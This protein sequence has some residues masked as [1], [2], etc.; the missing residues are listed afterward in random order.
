MSSSSDAKPAKV[1]KPRAKKAVKAEDADLLAPVESFVAPAVV[2]SAAPAPAVA[3]PAVAAP[4]MAAPVVAAPMGVEAAFA[5]ARADDPFAT[6]KYRL[7]SINPGLCVGRRIDEKNPI[8]ETLP[9]APTANGKMWPEK[10]CTKKPTPGGVMCEGCAKKDAEA[11]AEPAKWFKG[12]YGRL[13]EPMY[14]KALV[15]GCKDYLEKYPSGIAG[16]TDGVVAS[17]AVASA[18]AVTAPA[19]KTKKAP[20]KKAA[21]AAPLADAEAPPA[22]TVVT[23]PVPTN[24]VVAAA[25]A[26]KPKKAPAKKSA[27]SAAT[28]ESVA[29]DTA[30]KIIEWITFIYEKRPV[31]LNTETG[32]VYEVDAT[33][34]IRAEMA[35]LD[36]CVGRWKDGAV[37]PYDLDDE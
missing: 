4:A 15:I 31:I 28:A 22:N 20:A 7:Q 35:L 29:A 30:P 5:A 26:P 10:Q 1:T 21:A 23:E 3:A 11:K 36:K 24:T 18:A 9:G 8:A 12:Y 13:D 6:N 14:W 16:V 32:K 25:P 34:S 19:P 37:D 17:A 33:K 27:A 2:A